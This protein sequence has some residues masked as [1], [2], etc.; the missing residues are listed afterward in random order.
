MGGRRLA[1]G[2]EPPVLQRLE[3]GAV[4]QTRATGARAAPEL[5]QR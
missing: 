2:S 1:A 3:H 5:D 4:L